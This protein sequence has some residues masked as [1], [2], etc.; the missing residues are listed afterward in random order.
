M[1]CVTMEEENKYFK[2]CVPDYE[3]PIINKTILGDM[4]DVCTC[5]PHNSIDIVVTD[6]PMICAREY[7]VFHRM[8]ER[9]YID[10][11]D[12]WLEAVCPILK[13]GA[14][15]FILTNWDLGIPIQSS[16][17]RNLFVRGRITWRNGDIWC[18]SKGEV[19]NLDLNNTFWDDDFSVEVKTIHREQKPEGLIRKLICSYTKEG[20]IILDPFVGSGTTSVVANELNRRYIGIDTQSLYCAITE[21]RLGR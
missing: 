13:D 15:V 10:Y 9:E 3:K 12:R 4:F 7:S 18:A 5:L 11:T 2:Q 1:L 21:K 19:F 17:R 20:D 6:P 8:E 16:L 14:P